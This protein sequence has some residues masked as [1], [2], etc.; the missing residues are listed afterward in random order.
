MSIKDALEL[1][2]SDF[3]EDE[4][5]YYDYLEY[6]AMK[7]DVVEDGKNEILKREVAKA[8][9]KAFKKGYKENQQDFIVNAYKEN[10][11]TEIIAKI[12]KTSLDKV[13]KIIK[14]Y[15]L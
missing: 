1:Y 11:S 9:N 5:D 2:D 12:C 6:L 3:I 13:N 4:Y 10:I 14:E 15:C 8:K 7:R